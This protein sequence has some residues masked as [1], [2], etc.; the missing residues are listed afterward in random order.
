MLVVVMGVAGSGKTTLGRLLAAAYQAPFLDA[1]AFHSPA[2]VAKM[3]QSLPLTEQERTPW[4][5]RTI[6][7]VNAEPRARCVL[8]C[9][10]LTRAIRERL[11]SECRAEVVFVYLRSSYETA[12]THVS[13]RRGHFASA[14]LLA[15]QFQTLEEPAADEGAIVVDA[16]D[17]STVSCERVVAQLSLGMC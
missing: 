16:D 4:I 8:A 14:G 3:Q 1:D 12:H 7:R 15:S 13:S 10:A 2:A 17:P 9:S 11:R 6:A 5:S